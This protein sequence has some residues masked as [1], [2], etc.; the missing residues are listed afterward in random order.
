MTNKETIKEEKRPWYYR[1]LIIYLYTDGAEKNREYSKEEKTRIETW[2]TEKE[3]Y[4]CEK[5]GYNWERIFERNLDEQTRP[6]IQKTIRTRFK[7]PN[8]VFD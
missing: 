7:N 2:R 8:G 5:C 3:H 4:Q 6:K 1:D